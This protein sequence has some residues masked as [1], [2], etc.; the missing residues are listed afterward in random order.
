MGP[1]PCDK[2]C[3]K[4]LGASV[5][6]YPSFL[7]YYVRAKE[8]NVANG[9]APLPKNLRKL[10]G[11]SVSLYSSFPAC[12]VCAKKEHVANGNWPWRKNLRR[13]VGALVSLRFSFSAFSVGAK[14]EP[15]QMGMGH[16]GKFAK[17]CRSIDFTSLF[18]FGFCCLR[19]KRGR[20]KGEWVIAD[21]LAENW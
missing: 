4:P 12:S 5:P 3:E 15:W 21:T 16:C 17:S 8:E 18:I 14:K 20:G 9:T 7:A 6:L 13:P 2:V 19:Q 10:L 1:R 11:T